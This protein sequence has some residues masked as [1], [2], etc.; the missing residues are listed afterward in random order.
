MYKKT[1]RVI[2]LAVI[3]A[4][5]LTVNGCGLRERFSLERG[6]PKD[7]EGG[8]AVDSDGKPIDLND[9]AGDPNNNSE[10]DSG[11]KLVLDELEQEI[12]ELLDLL[13]QLETVD[14]SDLEL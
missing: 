11:G 12:D 10:A 14:D 3:F 13:N 6:Q 8:T 4:F 9:Q 5:L 2:V 1:I 7:L